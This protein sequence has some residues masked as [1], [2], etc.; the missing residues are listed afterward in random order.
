MKVTLYTRDDCAECRQV[1]DMLA[2]IAA[3]E[4]FDLLEAKSPE[5]APAPCVR[6]DAPGSPFYRAE[7]LTEAQ[8]VEYLEEAR[9][10]VRESD[11][12]LTPSR[13]R[14]A[15]R[16]GSGPTAEYERTH[17]ARSFFWRHRV[18]AIVTSLSA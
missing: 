15:R 4:D 2:M 16:A 7:G 9:K 11:E 17:P 10:L 14:S 5:G 1:W 6:F 3:Y 12:R 13:A 18:G 8:F